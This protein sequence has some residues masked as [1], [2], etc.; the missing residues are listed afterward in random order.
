MRLVSYEIIRTRVYVVEVSDTKTK[1][2]TR[3]IQYKCALLD[4]PKI[5]I[6]GRFVINFYWKIKIR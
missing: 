6:F 5:R 3:G 1:Q 4:R 2:W